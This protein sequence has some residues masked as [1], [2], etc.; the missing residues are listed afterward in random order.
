LKGK[1]TL[2]CH[3][4]ADPDSLCSAF[5]TREL[6]AS[7][8]PEVKSTIVAPG[9]LSRLSRRIAEKLD[10]VVDEKPSLA[11]S[12]LLV[13]LDIANPS[14]IEDWRDLHSK[15]ETPK[16]FIDHHNYHP[17]TPRLAKL[18]IHDETA[19]STCEIVHRMYEKYGVTPSKTVAEAL[20]IGIYYDS[21]R[22][23]LGTSE[24]YHS[25]YRLLEINGKIE[26]LDLLLSPLPDRSE[27]IARLKAAQRVRIKDVKGWIIATSLLSSFQASAA[28]GLL[29]LGADVSVVVGKNKGGVRASMRATQRFYSE[30]SIDLG[31][32]IALPLGRD[33]EGSGAGHPTSAG[34]NG[35]GEPRKL[36]KAILKILSEKI[37]N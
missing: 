9:G 34:F 24:T 35:E 27:K 5:A 30:T 31:R 16:V 1:V 19:S 26:E 14:Q 18:Y 6:F 37:L 7:L 8:N 23:S 4:N 25:I 2:I 36:V 20:L 21:K 13:F 17:E 28:R 29:A 10:I 32:D 22:F 12:N 15:N 11:N 3:D 33:F